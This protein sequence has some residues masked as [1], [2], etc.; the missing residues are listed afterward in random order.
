MT[1]LIH[2]CSKLV[3]AH[4]EHRVYVSEI[5]VFGQIFPPIIFTSFCLYTLMVL[6][7][8]CAFNLQKTEW[9]R[10]CWRIHNPHVLIGACQLNLCAY[11]MDAYMSDPGKWIGWLLMVNRYIHSGSGTSQCG[12][13]SFWLTNYWCEHKTHSLHDFSSLILY[14]AFQRHD[15]VYRARRKKWQGQNT[16]HSNSIQCNLYDYPLSE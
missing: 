13:A 2:H 9:H 4:S 16:L 11:K 15:K 10:I 12:L 5:S 14:L 8:R 3:S 1:N 6:A 7:N